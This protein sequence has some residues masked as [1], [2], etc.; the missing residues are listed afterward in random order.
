MYSEP[1][2]IYLRPGSVMWAVS[3]MSWLV[4]T[5]GARF[6]KGVKGEQGEPKAPDPRGH[7]SYLGS[8]SVVSPWLAI[9]TIAHLLHL[10]VCSLPTAK[11]KKTSDHLARF[12]HRPSG[13]GTGPASPNMEK[14]P[15]M[16]LVG[17]KSDWYQ[18]GSLVLVLPSLQQN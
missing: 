15:A 14:T 9:F 4:S 6:F 10:F 13:T 17:K 18:L 2:I 12:S 8:V 16:Q 7:F 5:Q 11:K 3:L 1:L